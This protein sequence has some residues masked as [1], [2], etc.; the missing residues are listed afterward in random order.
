[1][2]SEKKK[3]Q[4]MSIP[5]R[6]YTQTSGPAFS[7]T[8]YSA[9]IPLLALNVKQNDAATG[10]LAPPR[11]H[12]EPVFLKQFRLQKIMVGSAHLAQSDS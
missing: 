3:R 10:F 12:P 11:D 9:T 2:Q 5:S 4:G 1:M 6:F 8:C 7:L